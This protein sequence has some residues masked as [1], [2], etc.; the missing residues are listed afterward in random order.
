MKRQP[1]LVVISDVHLG[2]YG[3]HAK[4]LLNYLKSI[5][6]K[7][8]ILNGD[9]I[10][11]WQFR[12]SYFPPSHMQVI[13]RI[14]KMAANGC[15]VYYLTGNHD[16]VLR[17]YSDLSIGNIQLRDKLVIQLH[18]KRI[19]IFHGD[20]FD[21]FIRY[22]P[23]ITKMVSNGYELLIRLN[24][25][26]NTV[27]HRMGKPRMSIAARVKSKVK[28]AV[29]L[30]HDFEQT[31]I[32]LARKHQYDTVICG[33]IHNPQIRQEG[34]VLYL[35]AGDWVENLTALEYEHGGWKIY[36]YNEFDYGLPNPKLEVRKKNGKK[37]K[38]DTDVE[39]IDD[40]LKSAIVLSKP[41]T[42]KS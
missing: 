24:R 20:V 11:I 12:K 31:A 28:E 29:K 40:A 13:Q 33:H 2:T 36:D 6:P 4:E 9:F 34:G 25:F 27:R 21:L 7:I 3:C 16:D 22:S 41:T 26:I 10:D 15:K 8:L 17:R 18:G 39:V 35:N 14:L 37:Q 1:D 38:R 23:F 42:N 32:A 19:W 30:I 5:Q